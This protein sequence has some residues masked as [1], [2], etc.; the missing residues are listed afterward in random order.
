[1]FPK[2]TRFYN[3]RIGTFFTSGVVVSFQVDALRILSTHLHIFREQEGDQ[4]SLAPSC[5]EIV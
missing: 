1:M 5:W 2:Q 4:L 3:A